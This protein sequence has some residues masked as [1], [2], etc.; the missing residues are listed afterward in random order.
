MCL[1]CR[2][3][4]RSVVMMEAVRTRH[5]RS[6]EAGRIGGVVD[7]V[8]PSTRRKVIPGAGGIRVGMRS[9]GRRCTTREWARAWTEGSDLAKSGS[10]RRTPV[11]MR[12]GRGSERCR[13]A[14]AIELLAALKQASMGVQDRRG[15]RGPVLLEAQ[16]PRT[17]CRRYPRMKLGVLMSAWRVGQHWSRRGRRDCGA[18]PDE[19]QSGRLHYSSRDEFPFHHNFLNLSDV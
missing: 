10:G 14:D 2:A 3:C 15:S 16:A 4:A 13:R 19:V 12:L 11:C 7:P 8:K 5:E 17:R 18:W 6:I 9:S 1:T